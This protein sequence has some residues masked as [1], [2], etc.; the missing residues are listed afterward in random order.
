[1]EPQAR[2][3]EHLYKQFSKRLLNFIVQRVDS[4]DEAEDILHD[5][6]LKVHTNIESLRDSTTIESWLYQVTRNAIIDYYRARKPKEALPEN[7]IEETQTENAME[8]LT[9][10]IKHFIERLPEPYREAI[11]LTELQGMKQKDLASKLGISLSGAKS[12]VQRARKMLKDLFFECCHFEF[13]RY[14]TVID[15]HPIS[16][17]CCGEATENKC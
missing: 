14:G 16:C 9:P 1:M 10:S 15:Y 7:I 13:D 12:R 6:F 8:Q 17:C 11:T 3:L 5:V 2:Y 4:R